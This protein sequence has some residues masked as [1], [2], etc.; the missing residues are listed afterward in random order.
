MKYL[1]KLKKHSQ[2]HLLKFESNLN[3]GTAKV[4]ITGGEV[5]TK[6][7]GGGIR[8]SKYC[9]KMIMTGGKIESI[10]VNDSDEVNATN[11]AINANK[12]IISISNHC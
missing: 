10:L 7:T 12:N 8:I 2:E 6:A 1:E 3:V 5:Y 4:T 11:A 9:D